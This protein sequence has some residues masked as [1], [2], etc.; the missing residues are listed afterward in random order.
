[1]FTFSNMEVKG[2]RGRALNAENSLSWCTGFGTAGDAGC[3][4]LSMSNEIRFKQN[5][6]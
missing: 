2:S 5:R 6:Q 1:M 3:L 4:T